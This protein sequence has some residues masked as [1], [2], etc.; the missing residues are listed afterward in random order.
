MRYWDSSALIPLV[1]DE[2]RADQVRSFIIEDSSIISWWGTP[3][4]CFSALCRRKKE[5]V[6][7]EEDF[8]QARKEFDQ[9]MA[10]IDLVT[11]SRDLRE[12]ALKV[13]SL[14]ALR[15]GDAFQLAAALR[16]CREQSR[17]A[18]LVTLDDRLRRAA[19]D[20]GFTVLP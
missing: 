8:S 10:E 17:G 12:R 5:G 19:L 14:H 6:L 4:E 9:L 3:V 1:L 13:I 2:P 18:V 16:W 7:K 15:S 11:P 20:E